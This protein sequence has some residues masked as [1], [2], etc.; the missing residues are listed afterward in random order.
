VTRDEGLL[1]ALIRVLGRSG[2]GA[3]GEQRG[4][5]VTAVDHLGGELVVGEAGVAAQ[6]L[7]DELDEFGVADVVPVACRV[8]LGLGG[9]PFAVYTQQAVDAGEPVHPAWSAAPERL[10][11]L[12]QQTVEERCGRVRVGAVRKAVARG[13]VVTGGRGHEVHAIHSFPEVRSGGDDQYGCRHPG[14]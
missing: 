13:G 5:R 14:S 10:S 9:P 12:A 7:G 1:G 2:P 8:H 3:G 4:H 6:F 11:H